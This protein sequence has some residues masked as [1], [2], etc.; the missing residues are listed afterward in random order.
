MNNQ[1]KNI[2]LTLFVAIYF[3]IALTGKYDLAS[4]HSQLTS[5][6]NACKFETSKNSSTKT[7]GTKYIA[8][9]PRSLILKVEVKF[10]SLILPNP[11]PNDEKF[12]LIQTLSLFPFKSQ[13]SFVRYLP[14]DPPTT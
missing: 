1:F 7:N 6:I 2:I 4:N 5:Y 9:K 14:R 13:T 8:A 11:L 10:N 12:V 3:I